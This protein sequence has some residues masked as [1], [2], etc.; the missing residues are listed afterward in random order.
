MLA[1]LNYNFAFIVSKCITEGE[2][3]V[4]SEYW[5]E[6]KSATTVE[7]SPTNQNFFTTRSGINVI[8]II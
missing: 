6:E 7:Y 8:F 2:N 4:F 5:R 3:V 1:T